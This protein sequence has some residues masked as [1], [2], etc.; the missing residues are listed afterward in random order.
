MVVRVEGQAFGVQ[1]KGCRVHDP[2]I[3]TDKMYLSIIFRM[4]TPPQNRQLNFLI[5]GS[6]Q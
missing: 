1:G 5:G 3:L 4:S 6:K 2:F